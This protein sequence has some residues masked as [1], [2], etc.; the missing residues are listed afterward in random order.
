MGGSS[1][2]R[3]R[4]TSDLRGFELVFEQRERVANDLV[5]VGGAELGGGGAG[6]VEQAVGDFGG[7]EALLG[8]L[9]EHRAEA[10]IAPQLLGEHLRVGGDDGERGV[11]F[12]GHAG[13]EQ[14]DG[15]ELVG[16]GEL[17]FKGDALGDV[18][19]QD[20]A[21]DGNEVA[22]E[23]RRD[24]DVGGAQLAGAGG[25]AELV[26]VVHALLAAEAFERLDELRG[27]DMCE[28]SG[29]GPRRG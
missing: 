21:A 25:E 19:D 7:A 2:A 22:G 10:G 20:D 1:S 23:Q 3:S 5:E 6:E 16:L 28:R 4:S 14:A 12:V 15:A 9:V 24:G 27:E 13:G 11:D 29:R 8:D 26:K 17:G 18:V